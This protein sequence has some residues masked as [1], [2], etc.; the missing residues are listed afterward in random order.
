MKNTSVSSYNIPQIDGVGKSTSS[1]ENNSNAETASSSQAE[2]V[3][4]NNWSSPVEFILSCL[5]YAIG[6]GNIWRFPNLAFR[7]DFIER[8][9]HHAYN[10][11]YNRNGGGAFLLPYLLSAI[12]IGLPIFFAELIAG[13]YSGIGPIKAYAYLAPLFKGNY[14]QKIMIY[15]EKV[16]KETVSN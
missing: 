4:R 6:L 14:S 5:S 16:S 3:A 8:V 9:I 13:Q 7:W 12:F 2:L 15:V 1:F 10:N 11:F